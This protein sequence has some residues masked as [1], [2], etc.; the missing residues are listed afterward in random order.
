MRNIL[1]I[2]L[3]IFTVTACQKGKVGDSTNAS[4]WSNRFS[5]I[6]NADSLVKGSSYLPVYS[7]IY[8]QHENKTYNLT[9]TA[10]IRN[11]SRIDTV[12]IINAD[13]FN[14]AG[15]KIRSYFSRPIFVRPLETVEIVIGENDSAGG[16]GGN[17]IFD[18]AVKSEKQIPLFEAVMISTTGQQGLSFTTR[19]VRI[20]DHI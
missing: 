13:Y 2:L 9:V 19:G 3:L 16:T 11:V 8:Q 1:C 6:A 10:S 17:F 7:Q 20:F 14:T 18:W 12:Y 15:E 4:S 5:D